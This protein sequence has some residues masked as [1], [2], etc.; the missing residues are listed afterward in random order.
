LASEGR[1]E[2]GVRRGVFR[3]RARCDQRIAT[4]RKTVTQTAAA[5]PCALS[6]DTYLRELDDARQD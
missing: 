2:E 5:M 6:S 1:S 3:A 4:M